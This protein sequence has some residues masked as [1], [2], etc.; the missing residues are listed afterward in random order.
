M[1]QNQPDARR[2]DNQRVISGIVLKSGGR[3]RDGPDAYGP[4]TT[5][6]NRSDRVSPGL[7][8]RHAHRP[9]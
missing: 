2:V 6:Y 1:P 8:A 3:W 9:G 4:H 7:L 5:V